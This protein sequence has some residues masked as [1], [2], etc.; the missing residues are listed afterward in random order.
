MTAEEVFMAVTLLRMHKA[1]GEMTE[2]FKKN[3]L[4]RH[5]GQEDKYDF[6]EFEID[7]KMLGDELKALSTLGH[8]QRFPKDL[9]LDDQ[10]TMVLWNVIGLLGESSELAGLLL[11]HNLRSMPEAQVDLATRQEWTKELGDVAWYHAEI[12]TKLGLSLEDIQQATVERNIQLAI[13]WE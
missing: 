6:E 1:L 11:D 12:A 3:I 9:K 4:H 2:V 5:R 7:S 10:N 13:S 8:W